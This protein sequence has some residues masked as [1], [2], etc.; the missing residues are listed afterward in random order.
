MYLLALVTFTTGSRSNVTVV[1]TTAFDLVALSANNLS[2]TAGGA[3]TDSGVLDIAGAAIFTTT[4][5]NGNVELDQ[6]SDVDGTLGTTTNGSGIVSIT[7]LTDAIDIGS[8]STTAL[9][10]G[11][12]G[13]ITDTAG[14]TIAVNGLAILSNAGSDVITLGDDATDLTNFNSLNK[15][16]PWLLYRRI[17]IL[18]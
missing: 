3:I 16:E 4:A 2:V 10:L 1:D 6:A 12:A 18:N 11:S 9:T 5:S 14:A 7:N 13:A 8:I 17:V 15:T